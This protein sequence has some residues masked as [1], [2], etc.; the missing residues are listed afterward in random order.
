MTTKTRIGSNAIFTGPQQGLTIIGNHCYAYSGGLEIDN[1]P[2]VTMLEFTTGK[3][4]IIAKLSFGTRDTDLSVNTHI[5]YEIYFNGRIVFTTFS[6]SDSDG[7]L[8]YDGAC[9]PQEILIPPLTAVKI[10]GFTSDPNN[11]SCFMMLNGS[12]YQ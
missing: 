5:G 3:Q 6:L 12:V 8:F 4:Y 2:D 1:D 7:T 10:E 9:F 11:I